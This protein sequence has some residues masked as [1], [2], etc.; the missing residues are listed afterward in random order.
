M[1]KKQVLYVARAGLPV[2]ATGIRIS[3]IGN[4]FE[5]L[6][7]NVHYVCEKRI[8]S[9]L[10]YESGDLIREKDLETWMNKEE[11]HFRR[12]NKVYSY[13]PAFSGKKRDA[14]RDTAEIVT[15]HVAFKRLKEYCEKES[16]EIVILYNDVYSLTKKMIPFCKK[17]GIKLMADVTEWYEKRKDSTIPEKILIY[18]TDCRIRRL[19]KYLDGVIAISKYFYNYYQKSRVN[20]L[21]IPPLMSMEGNIEVERHSNTQNRVINFV[22]AGSPGSK[23]ILLPF[24]RAIQKGNENGLR[25]RLDLIGVSEDAL[26]GKG[27]AEELPRIGIFAHGRKSHKETVEIIRKSDFGILFRYDKRYAKAGYSTK[28]AECMSLGVAMICNKIGGT[29]SCIQSWENGIITNSYDEN[30]LVCLLERIWQMEDDE[31]IGMRKCAQQTAK[32]MYDD[33]QYVYKLQSFIDTCVK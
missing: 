11:V 2:D 9:T 12:D 25:F 8:D 15:A 5:K 22:Y 31:I 33:S 27:V 17:N 26:R 6:G 24:L 28:F 32:Q 3:R 20:C 13:F 21:W 10:S 1:L 4:L 19:D 29:E 18:L 14:I 30:E 7:Y 16:P 23:D